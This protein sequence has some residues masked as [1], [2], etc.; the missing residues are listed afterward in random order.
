MFWSNFFHIYQPFDQRPEILERIVNESY[1]PLILGWKKNPRAHIT[2]NINACLTEMLLKQ[3][4]LDV[5]KDLAEL[6]E[7]GQLEFTASGKFH[8]FLPILPKKEIVRQIKIN[9]ETNSKI[10]GKAYAPKGF[11][12]PEMGYS[13]EVGEVVRDLGYKWVVLDEIAFNGRIDEVKYDRLYRLSLRAPKGRGNLLSRRG[14][15]TNFY[16]ASDSLAKREIDS[17]I[18]SK[19][20]AIGEASKNLV[21]PSNLYVFFRER[22]MSNLIMAAM[23]RTSESTWEA[24]GVE[25]EKNRY[26][27]TAMDGETFGHHRPG[28]EKMLDILYSD[29]RYELVT[30]S[31]LLNKFEGTTEPS[32]PVSC[33]C[34]TSEGEIEKGQNFYLYYN[35]QNKL[36]VLQKQLIDLAIK[37]GDRKLLDS[38]LSCNHMWWSNPDA[39]WSIEEIEKGAYNL[40]KCILHDPAGPRNIQAKAEEL[41]QKIMAQAF[42]WQRE[43]LPQKLHEEKEQ[44]KKIPFKER[45]KP[46]EMDAIVAILKVE[47]KNAVERHEYELAIRWR[48]SRY[49]LEKGLDMY[50]FVHIV[51]QMRA[52]GKMGKYNELAAKFRDQYKK[53]VPGQ[54]DK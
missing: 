21:T 45:A 16:S 47:E 12:P 13:R 3:K 54:A 17:T 9:E 1:R 2:L 50:D 20:L 32:D 22:R 35:P 25:N 15:H 28:L 33:S 8:P 52:E 42:E 38:A 43:G 39:W 6:A 29:P 30:V 4:Y 41:Y 49:K 37:F 24:V 53:F 11:F 10:F 44:F 40:L 46:G 48:D 14:S 27:I 18:K 5:I 31:E 36:H 34:A 23:L 7:K 26:L 19:S 51:D